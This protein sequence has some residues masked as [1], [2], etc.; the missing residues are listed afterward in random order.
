[1][2]HGDL[3]LGNVLMSGKK[4]KKFI[5]ID[6]ERCTPHLAFPDPQERLLLCFLEKL[7][8]FRF[9]FDLSADT[10]LNLHKDVHDLFVKYFVEK[11]K[12]LILDDNWTARFR[13]ILLDYVVEAEEYRVFISA[14]KDALYNLFHTQLFECNSKLYVFH[15]YLLENRFKKLVCI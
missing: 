15:Q 11:K 12:D 6:F 7:Y 5:F 4:K 1:M 8:V 3:H 14:K 10:P 9:F 2:Y 13:P